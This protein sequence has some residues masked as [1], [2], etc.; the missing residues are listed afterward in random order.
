MARNSN[1]KPIK[2]GRI[3]PECGKTLEPSNSEKH[4]KWYCKNEACPLIS[5]KYDIKGE[6]PYDVKKEGLAN[7]GERPFSPIQYNTHLIYQS[8]ISDSKGGGA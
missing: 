1:F 6:I 8:D 3:C 7:F 4:R 2:E 5:C